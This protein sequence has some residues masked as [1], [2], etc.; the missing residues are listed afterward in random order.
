VRS[1]EALLNEERV[2]RLLER[3]RQAGLGVTR[4][5]RDFVISC[6]SP[7][8]IASGWQIAQARCASMK[9]STLGCTPITAARSHK[10]SLVSRRLCGEGCA[11]R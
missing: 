6:S 2:R 7:V 8:E 3:S 9:A 10:N 4:L 5:E 11:A 1:G